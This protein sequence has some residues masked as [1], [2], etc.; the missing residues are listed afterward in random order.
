MLTNE[1]LNKLGR[2]TFLMRKVYKQSIKI[3]RFLSDVEYQNQMLELA[4]KITDNT[5]D[6]LLELA[7]ALSF[8]LSRAA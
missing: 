7:S 6:E 3:D 4:A 2:F 1:Q 8:S 5:N